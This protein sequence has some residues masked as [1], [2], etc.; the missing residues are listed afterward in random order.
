M[1]QYYPVIVVFDQIS[2][3]TF[4]DKLEWASL[5]NAWSGTIAWYQLSPHKVELTLKGLDGLDSLIITR[6]RRGDRVF[7][8]ARDSAGELIQ[9]GIWEYETDSGL[10]VCYRRVYKAAL[11]TTLRERL[12][13]FIFTT[14][15]R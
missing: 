10:C 15:L 3:N 11:A 2:K 12:S 1:A 13:D 4:F 9:S 14:F 6:R 5:V 8:G 7:I